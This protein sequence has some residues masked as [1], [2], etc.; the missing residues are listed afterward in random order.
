M[1]TVRLT[2]MKVLENCGGMYISIKGILFLGVSYFT[3]K[4]LNFS[5]IKALYSYEPK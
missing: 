2:V 3:K 4:S 5:M 1:Y